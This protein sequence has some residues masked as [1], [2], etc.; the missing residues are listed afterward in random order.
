M[1]MQPS[2]TDVDAV[3]QH[4]DPWILAGQQMAGQP[5]GPCKQALLL[6]IFLEFFC[7]VLDGYQSFLTPGSSDG[8]RSTVPCRALSGVQQGLLQ[9]QKRASSVAVSGGGG[10]TVGGLPV[11]P[12]VRSSMLLGPLQ[13]QCRVDMTAMLDHHAATC[14]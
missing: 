3:G 9:M 8:S 13:P 14:G 4:T 2:V 1:L 6:R 7:S 11:V 12:P 10:G 5:W